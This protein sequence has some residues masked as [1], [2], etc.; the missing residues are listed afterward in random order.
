MRVNVLYAYFIHKAE[1]DEI[2]SNYGVKYNTVRNFINT[3]KRESGMQYKHQQF[4]PRNPIVL[5]PD[6]IQ[7]KGNKGGRHLSV[8]QLLLPNNLPYLYEQEEELKLKSLLDLQ[9]HLTLE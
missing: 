8:S 4:D 6:Q 7:D 1:L 2:A 3:F 5:P 9:G